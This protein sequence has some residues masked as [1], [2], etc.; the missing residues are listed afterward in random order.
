[1]LALWLLVLQCL[2]QASLDLFDVRA[3]PT[4]VRTST[5]CAGTSRPPDGCDVGHILHPEREFGR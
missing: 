2:R 4:S 1:M 3:G 5:G